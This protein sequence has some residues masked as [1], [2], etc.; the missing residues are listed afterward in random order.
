MTAERGRTLD[1]LERVFV[2]LLELEGFFLAE[3]VLVEDL[4]VEGFAVGG[5]SLVAVGSMG[6]S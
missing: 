2:L 1:L 5:A 6:F 3:A 4:L